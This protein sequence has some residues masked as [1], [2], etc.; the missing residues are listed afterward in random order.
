MPGALPE[1]IQT[2]HFLF[3]PGPLSIAKLPEE[4]Q[5]RGWNGLEWNCLAWP[6]AWR[7]AG[8]RGDV[9]RDWP[10]GFLFISCSCWTS[11]PSAPG[12]RVRAGPS[13]DRSVSR[14]P[15]S[16]V[17]AASPSPPLPQVCVAS[18]CPG[19][20]WDTRTGRP[21]GRDPTATAFADR[22]GLA[23]ADG[24]GIASPR[25]RRGP[26]ARKDVYDVR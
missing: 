26:R 4:L 17:L 11:E 14:G 16:I 25:G 15:S 7:L 21:V 24:R 22:R 8:S 19:P 18:A 6:R 20:T 10:L 1:K 13:P 5:E 3:F 23:T 2:H 12:P 9:T